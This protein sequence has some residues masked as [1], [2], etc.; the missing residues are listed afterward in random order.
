MSKLIIST[1]LKQYLWFLSV[2]EAFRVLFFIYYFDKTRLESFYDIITSFSASFLLDNSLTS[3]LMVI[4]FFLLFFFSQL[5]WN[6]LWNI[7]KY[8]SYLIIIILIIIESANIMIYG[9]WGIKLNYKALSYL[10]EPSEAIHSARIRVLIIGFAIIALFIFIW[11][12]LTKKI[13]VF[14]PNSAKPSWVFSIIWFIVM[15]FLIFGGM[16]GSL[17]QI[18]I[19]QSQSYHSKSDFIN[20]ASVNTSWNLGQSILENKKYIDKNPFVYFPEGKAQQIVDS[21]YNYPV[22]D[23]LKIFTTNKPNI[24]LIFL[25]SWSANFIDDLGSDLHISKGFSKLASEG[26]LFTNLYASGTLSHQGISAVLS[27]IP[28]TPFTNI[29]KQ[30][31]KYQGMQCMVKDLKSKGYESSFL[32]GGQLIYGN[33]KAYIY[34]NEFDHIMEGKDF[35]SNIP[36][37]SLGV[38]DQYMLSQL[39]TNIATYKQPFFASAFTLSSHSPFDMPVQNYVDFGGEFK[40]TLN[41]IYYADSCLYNFVQEAK[42]QPWYDNTVFVFVAD[43]GHPS[44]YKFPYY[45]REVRHIPLLIYGPVLKP[46][47]RGKTNGVLMSQTDIPAT[48]LAQLNIPNDKY[49]WSKNI[50][51]PNVP[52]FAYFGFDNGYGW[53]EPEEFY[54]YLK[55]ED[56][57]MDWK[58][59]NPADSTRL[60]RNGKAYIEVL[61]QEYLDL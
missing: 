5:R 10:S 22:N 19:S 44:P 45:S 25:E 15:P 12:F 33:I 61:Y 39:L 55:S 24:V 57:L 37:G 18:P 14:S 30:P 20:Q 53:I 1:F 35:D 16:R 56:R 54:S 41:S 8:Y 13:K 47:F 21:L 43:H 49:R 6:F 60:L 2:V 7:N 17:Q 11:L 48:I 9:E 58:F 52:Q 59:N 34:F 29:I 51:N 38:H 46:E 31:G 3:Y 36:K 50:L 26:Y 4:P 28:S 27:G 23:S 42:K 32:F 40:K